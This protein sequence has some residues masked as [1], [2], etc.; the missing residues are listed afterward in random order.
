MKKRR[1]KGEKFGIKSNLLPILLVK[2]Y[3][4]LKLKKNWMLSEINDLGIFILILSCEMI[5]FK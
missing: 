3:F 5:G 1:I 2:D 4:F